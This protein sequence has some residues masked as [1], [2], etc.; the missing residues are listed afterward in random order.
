MLGR[1]KVGRLSEK[2][3]GIARAAANHGALVH[4]AAFCPTTVAKINAS[5]PMAQRH[6]YCRIGRALIRM[7][8]AFMSVC[9]GRITNILSATAL[10]AIGAFAAALPP[11]KFTFSYPAAVRHYPTLSSWLGQEEHRVRTAVTAEAK[12]DQDEA[13]KD[14]HPFHPYEAVRTWKEV[15]NTPRFLSLSLEFYDYTNGAH[16]NS[17]FA[18]TVWDKTTN[19]RRASLSFFDPQALRTA[20]TADFCRQLDAER[21]KKR[22]NEESSPTDFDACIDPTKQTLILGSSNRVTFDRLGFLIAPYEAGPYAEGTYEVTL[23]VTPAILASVRP[24]WR[25]F[26]ALMPKAR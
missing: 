13:A 6:G 1:K 10:I 20:A 25:R 23:P 19:S 4:M 9:F 2:R 16:G 3:A 18:S 7:V 8:G 21:R 11:A 22:A 5:L 26:F 14:H 12:A 17:G 15:T 24:Q